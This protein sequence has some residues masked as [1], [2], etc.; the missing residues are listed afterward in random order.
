MTQIDSP[1]SAPLPVALRLAETAS[2][3]QLYDWVRAIPRT[4]PVE[5]GVEVG[6]FTRT[7][8]LPPPLAQALLARKE[9]LVDLVLASHSDDAETLSNLW[10][11]DDHPLRLAI[12]SNPYRPGWLG[13]DQE[14]ILELLSSPDPALLKAALANPSMLSGALA[15]L[16]R[17]D[18]PYDR[19]SDANWLRAIA[20]AADAPLLR[21]EESLDDMLKERFAIDGWCDYEKSEAIYAAWSLVDRLEPTIEAA[22]ILEGLIARIPR[23]TAPAG[24]AGFDAKAGDGPK[25]TSKRMAAARDAFVL[26]AFAKWR[27]ENVPSGAEPVR[28]FEPDYHAGLRLVIAAAAAKASLLEDELRAHAD[29]H[30]RLGYYREGRKWTEATVQEAF[31]R[32]GLEFLR[33][34]SNNAFFYERRHRA[35]AAKLRACLDAL[36]QNGILFEDQQMIRRTLH[37]Y[38]SYL[39][40]QDPA[41]YPHPDRDDDGRDDTP[42]DRLSAS[43]HINR[44]EREFGDHLRRLTLEHEDSMQGRRLGALQMKQERVLLRALG[45]HGNAVLGALRRVAGE[46]EAIR[47]HQ[48]ESVETFVFRLSKNTYMPAIVAGLVAGAVVTWLR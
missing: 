40:R 22:A 20:A 26:S 18:E 11:R 24:K 28:Q 29:Q 48:G 33:E 7:Q 13:L 42:E 23:M 27:R 30:I 3:A 45:T 15:R 12:A 46:V 37:E 21:Q 1:L 44:A 25:S 17:R 35:L 16:F 9:P 31:E 34:A 8:V 32:D 4:M 19:L 14:M 36:R 10:R 5:A 6:R 43:E 39:W 41:T 47:H 38:G 2:A